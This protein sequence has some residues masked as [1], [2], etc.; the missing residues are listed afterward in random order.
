MIDNFES[1]EITNNLSG[2]K[3]L[4]DRQTFCPLRLKINLSGQL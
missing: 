2:Q 1:A 4:K 3:K